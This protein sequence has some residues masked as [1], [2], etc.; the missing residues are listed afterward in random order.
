M[1]A[2][3][4]KQQQELSLHFALSSSERGSV[5][6]VALVFLILTSMIAVTTM[7]TSVIQ[8]QMAGNNQFR[9]DAI[10]IAEGIQD[11]IAHGESATNG[12]LLPLDAAAS[13][14]FLYC[15][16]KNTNSDCD[17]FSLRISSSGLETAIGTAT[18]TYMAQL[19]ALSNSSYVE[20][21]KAGNNLYTKYRLDVLYDGTSAGLAQSH[22]SF[23][24]EKTTFAGESTVV[25]PKG[26]NG[27][28]LGRFRFF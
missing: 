23:M 7:N 8:I 9:E 22:L 25:S 1:K 3:K 19:V 4:W 2:N 16:L 26:D 10:L 24:L 12:E 21:R 20:A 11:D 27:E 17:K 13:K 14:G 15:D 6:L 5:L 28:D 18:V